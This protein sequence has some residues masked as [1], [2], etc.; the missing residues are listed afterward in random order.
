MM[1]GH[2]GQKIL[3]SV[4]R[5]VTAETQKRVLLFFANTGR[6]ITKGSGGRV[7]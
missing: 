2:T 5:L 1:N 4:S 7:K 3:G 6:A